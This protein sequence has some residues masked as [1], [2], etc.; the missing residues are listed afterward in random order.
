MNETSNK[1]ESRADPALYRRIRA[2]LEEAIL[3]GKWPPGHRIPFEHE[4][5]VRYDCARMTV[6]RAVS[7]LVDSGLVERRR[8]AGTFVAQRKVESAVLNIPNL[9]D[10]VKARGMRYSYRR[11]SLDRRAA[12]AEDVKDYGVEERADIIEIRSL[13]FAD[14]IPLVCELRLIHVAAVPAVADLTFEEASPGSWLLAHVPWTEAQHR[15]SAVTPDRQTTALLEIPR[16]T[17]CLC[18]ERRTWRNGGPVTFARQI[19]RGD[20]YH[21][22]AHFVPSN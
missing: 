6:N 19:F 11:L 1:G 22:A 2:D 9:A 14:D 18:L 10:E 15:I 17:A 13:H 4:L 20:M 3:S 12:G 7:A 21:F 5:M 16:N 8:R